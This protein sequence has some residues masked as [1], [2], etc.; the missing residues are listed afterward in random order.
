MD[1]LCV[2][3]GKEFRSARN[4]AINRMKSTYKSAEKILVFDNSLEL[5]D[6]TVAPEE[7]VIRLRYSPWSTRLWTMQEGRLGLKVYLQFRDKSK[8][9]DDQPYQNGASGNLPA[10]D[11]ILKSMTIQDIVSLNR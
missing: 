5:V 6:S 2:P 11:E 10:V 4:R 8:S 7:A 1:T 9:F 3:V